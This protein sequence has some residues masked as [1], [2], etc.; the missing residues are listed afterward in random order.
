LEEKNNGCGIFIILLFI[1]IIFI[2]VLV[3]FCEGIEGSIVG[4]KNT[5]YAKYKHEFDSSIITIDKTNYHFYYPIQSISF[6]Q[7]SADFSGKLNYE[8]LFSIGTGEIDSK[9]Y[10]YVY[11]ETDENVFEMK[12]FDTSTT[13]LYLTD[14]VSPCIVAKEMSKEELL[15][16][17]NEQIILV[18][19][20]NSI[21]KNIKI[22]L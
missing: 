12:K 7:N 17:E 2:T 16:K 5:K 6:K 13:K 20:K 14:E 11:V 9:N 22:N 18:V 1:G 4:I 8:G 3:I 15:K 19:P 10:Y 21:T